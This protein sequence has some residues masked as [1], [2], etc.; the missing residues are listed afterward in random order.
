MTR[1]PTQASWPHPTGRG[2]SGARGAERR[3]RS[4]ARGVGRR[5]RSGARGVGRRFRSGARGVGRGSAPPRARADPSRWACAARAACAGS[6]EAPCAA[7]VLRAVPTCAQAW[8]TC[9]GRAVPGRC[10]AR[11]ATAAVEAWRAAACG[12]LAARRRGGAAAR[13]GAMRRAAA[14]STRAATAR[15]AGCGAQI[16][17]AARRWAEVRRRGWRMLHC[18]L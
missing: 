6:G 16:A 4:G 7:T 14:R 8:G 11:R 5:F 17:P 1:R 13:G 9:R 18:V 2:R 3:F 15:G 10:C 12:G